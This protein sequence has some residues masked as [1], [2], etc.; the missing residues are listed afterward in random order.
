M[1]FRYF[2]FQNVRD[3]LNRNSNIERQ[4]KVPFLNGY[5]SQNIV[6]LIFWNF[7]K[8]WKIKSLHK[9]W[10]FSVRDFFDKC[11][12]ICNFLRIC[13]QILASA[14]ITLRHGCS[15][16][17]LLYVFRT[18][19]PTITSE[20][21]LLANVIIFPTPLKTSEFNLML[22]KTGANVVDTFH[23]NSLDFAANKINIT[24]QWS[25]IYSYFVKRFRNHIGVLLSML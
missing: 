20:L 17:N 6:S 7:E 21:L 9:E 4:G 1:N 11:E 16:I 12:K 3:F 15:P 13:S 10:K 2:D 18:F 24:N 14:I 19:F 23:E 22:M 8:N 25:Q 5:F